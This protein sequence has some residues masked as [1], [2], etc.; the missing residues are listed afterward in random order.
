M[1]SSEQLRL[2]N[3]IY[4]ASLSSASSELHARSSITAERKTELNSNI[5]LGL[6][7]RKRI[8]LERSF[9]PC[10]KIRGPMNTG[11]QV[12]ATSLTPQHGELSRDTPL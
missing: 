8:L 4:T 6:R 9:L 1:E 12:L 7:K 3:I 11:H 5:D 2:S 10:S